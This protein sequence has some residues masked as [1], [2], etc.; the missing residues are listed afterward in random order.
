MFIFAVPKIGGY[1]GPL[2]QLLFINLIAFGIGLPVLMWLFR[3][4]DW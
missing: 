3:K 4:M 2:W 1:D